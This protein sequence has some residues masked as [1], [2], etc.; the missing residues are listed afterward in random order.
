MGYD[1][2]GRKICE[3]AKETAGEPYAI[4][5]TPRTGPSGLR[6]DGA[7]LAL[8]DVEVVDARGRRCPIALNQINFTLAGPGEWR[9][10]IAQGPGN[11]ILSKSLPV[12]C[13][14]NRVIIRAGNHPGRILLSATSAGLKEAKVEIASQPVQ[15]S[16]G[17]SLS[18]SAD[19]LPAYLGRG[20]TPARNRVAVTRTSVRIV[21][22]STGVN[23]EKALS[24][25]DDNE[26]TSW[27]N[28]GRLATAWIKYTLARPARIGEVTLKLGGW[29]TRAYPLRISVDDEVVFTGVT[30]QSLGYVTIPFS[31]AKGRSLKIELTG[32]ARAF[33][34]F[35]NIVEL[36]DPKNAAVTGGSGD[37][38]GTLEIVELEV[39]EPAVSR[40]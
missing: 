4:R 34:A 26:V 5:L 33:D 13:G 6:A 25:F 17:L 14:V 28:D 30:S 23:S 32:S 3:T 22:V 39:Y 18:S 8:V 36:T 9:G 35:G 37:A 27:S 16:N 21:G 40:R 24:S 20:P 1:A 2:R 12:E 15:M 31:P 10:G 38:K 19:L 11:Y 29:R 7:D